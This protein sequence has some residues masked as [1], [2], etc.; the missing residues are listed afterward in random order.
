[1]AEY[2]IVVHGGVC[3]PKEHA[4]GCEEAC[5]IGLAMLASGASALDA[6]VEAVSMMEDDGRFNAGSGSVLRIDGR[7]RQM[8]AAVMDSTGRIG[9]VIAI[10]DI[11]NPVLAARA[12][13][14]TPHV[15]LAGKGATTFAVQRG[16]AP[17]GEAPER[18]LKRFERLRDAVNAGKI[19]AEYLSWGGRDLRSLWNVDGIAY[20]EVFS[21]DTV[22]AVALD[23]EGVFAVATSTGG[24]F[25]MMLGRVGDTPMIGCGFYAGK[26]AAAACTGIGEEIIRTMLARDVCDRIVSGADPREACNDAMRSVSPDIPIGIICLSARGIGIAANRE[27]A[28]ASAII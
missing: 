17:I 23:R 15:A 19:G 7:T 18:V 3:T 2:G 5:R 26:I 22:G 28:H 21:T 10:E 4:D 6:A 24:A 20:D 16:F 8:D 25:P 11:R 12:V 13:L 27:M 9:A 14:E 1:M